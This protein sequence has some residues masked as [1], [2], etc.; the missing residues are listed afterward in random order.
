MTREKRGWA[1]RVAG[2]KSWPLDGAEGEGRKVRR[3]R[4]GNKERG[5]VI[6]GEGGVAGA[7]EWVGVEVEDGFAVGGGGDGDHRF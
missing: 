4:M 5:E 2:M 6:E 7:V 1:V 3:G